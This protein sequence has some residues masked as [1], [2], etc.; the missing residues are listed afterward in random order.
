MAKAADEFDEFDGATRPRI[1]RQNKRKRDRLLD[2][3]DVLLAVDPKKAPRLPNPTC[4]L[5][6]QKDGKPRNSI[7]KLGNSERSPEKSVFDTFSGAG[8]R[9]PVATAI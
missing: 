5:C 7:E 1:G 4:Q 2:Y 8:N 6:P 3:L 9:S